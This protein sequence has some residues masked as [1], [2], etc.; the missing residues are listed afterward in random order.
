VRKKLWQL[1]KRRSG[2]KSREAVR[3]IRKVL[4]VTCIGAP[5]MLNRRGK[6]GGIQRGIPEGL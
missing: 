1:I 5:R 3:A 6:A 2:K 4:L